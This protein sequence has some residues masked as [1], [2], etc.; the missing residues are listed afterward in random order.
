MSSTIQKLITN[1]HNFQL[2]KPAKSELISIG[3]KAVDLLIEELEKEHVT[4]R[5]IHAANSAGI[6]NFTDSHFSLIRPGIMMYGYY[7]RE[8]L[9]EKLALRKALQFKTRVNLIKEFPPQRVVGYGR[10]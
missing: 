2:R 5:S 1:L 7:P 8:S 6:L 10:K 3:E 4:F 9:Q